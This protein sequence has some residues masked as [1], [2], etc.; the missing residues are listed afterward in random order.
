MKEKL[1]PEQS[2][3]QQQLT[4]VRKEA[5][6]PP[7]VESWLRKAETLKPNQQAVIN[8]QSGQ[9]ILQST[10]PTNPV[11]KLPVS[12]RVVGNGLKLAVSNAGR[13]LSV[14]ILRLIKINKGNVE[15]KKEE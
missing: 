12:K 6:L 15:F 7:Q 4:D 10:T 8:D 5:D 3:E 1:T 13:W 11:V 14:F 2:L 9:P